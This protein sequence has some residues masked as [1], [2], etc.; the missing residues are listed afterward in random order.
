MTRK[1][2]IAIA[3]VLL[4]AQLCASEDKYNSAE[5]AIGGVA[6]EIASVFQQDNP[7]FDR[8][9]FMAAC[10]YVNA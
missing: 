9:R 4:Q 7:R 5:Q 6:R 3:K 2:Y 1:D 10:G 8:R